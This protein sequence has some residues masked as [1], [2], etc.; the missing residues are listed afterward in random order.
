MAAAV[1][2]PVGATRFRL[3]SAAVLSAQATQA[4]GGPET[5]RAIPA[6]HAR[7]HHGKH[8]LH[9][10]LCAYNAWELIADNVVL[11]VPLKG[12]LRMGKHP[13][14]NDI[15]VYGRGYQNALWSTLG[16]S[17]DASKVVRGHVQTV[18]IICR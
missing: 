14:G 13:G 8:A 4:P 7:A 9:L 1:A 15:A 6:R 17:R 3:N 2:L 10:P 16:G 11:I 18:I 12:G 5:G